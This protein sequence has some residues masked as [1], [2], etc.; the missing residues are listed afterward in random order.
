[1]ILTFIIL[2]IFSFMNKNYAILPKSPKSIQENIIK[3]TQS[4]KLLTSTLL[5]T[6]LINSDRVHATDVGVDGNFYFDK[7]N[8]F[9]LNLPNGFNAMPKKTPTARLMK[10]QVEESLFVAT[11]F[12][13]GAALSVTRSQV[14]KL[15]FDFQ[16]EWWFAPLENIKDVGNAQ[17]IAQLLILQR[18]G[19]FEKKQTPSEILN[20]QFDTNTNS[21][22]FEF[23]TPLAE[24][25]RRRTIVKSFF[26]PKDLTLTST[27]IS[28]LEN[29]YDQDFGKELFAIR[30]SF[31]KYEN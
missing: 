29:V 19:D 1:M 24:A 28:A 26:S 2:L 31:S 23:I 15:L 22:M 7:I 21:L 5:L 8:Q 27:W 4:I 12:N 30:N 14:R 3:S 6:N 16:I 10:Y 18:Q 11:Q 13:E 20:C 17:L 25:I 9:G